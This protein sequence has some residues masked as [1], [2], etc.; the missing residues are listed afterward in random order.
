ME[1]M[2]NDSNLYRSLIT[3]VLGMFL[4]IN[5]KQSIFDELWDYFSALLIF[6]LNFSSVIT[7]LRNKKKQKLPSRAL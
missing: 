1:N 3:T 6:I 4:V 2:N 7:I 5:L